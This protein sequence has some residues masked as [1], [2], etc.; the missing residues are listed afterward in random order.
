M[1]QK[2]N[3]LSA[4]FSKLAKRRVMA[5]PTDKM[6]FVI[7]AAGQSRRF[8]AGD[9]AAA[10]PKQFQL[11]SGQPVVLHSLRAIS[12]W[13]D[14]GQIMVVLPETGVEQVMRDQLDAAAADAPVRVHFTTGGRRAQ[15]QL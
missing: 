4:L 13:T 6:D 1:R 2:I 5:A 12:S 11:L 9:R 10:E 8:R 3:N 15:I 7:L 14:C